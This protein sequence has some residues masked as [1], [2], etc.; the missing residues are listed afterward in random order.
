MKRIAAE[1]IRYIKLGEG[2]RWERECLEKGI[3]RMGLCTGHPGAMKMELAGDWD[4][5]ARDWLSNGHSL[6][7]STRYTREIREFFEDDGT[8]LWVT[9]IGDSLHWGFL[10]PEPPEVFRPDDPEDETTFRRIRGGW[11]NTDIREGRILAKSSL[12][13]T[14]TNLASYRG[15]SC[16]VHDSKRLLARINCEITPEVARA[17]AA[18]AE[19]VASAVPLVQSLH[20][21]H[22]ETLVDMLFT[23]AGWRRVGAI[24][25]NTSIKDLD[26]EQPLTC[27]K[28]FVQVKCSTTQHALDAYVDHAA[29]MSHYQRLFFVYHSSRKPLVTDDPSVTVMDAKEVAERAIELGFMRWLLDMNS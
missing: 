26:L 1:K 19:L 10:E 13:G 6:S 17:E 22:F 29:Q 2:G 14:L 28:A 11:K 18:H 16:W 27:E 4:D 7:V 15:T 8:M 9:Y 24:G 23:A 25:G 21:K 5:V 3:L 12:P 20:D